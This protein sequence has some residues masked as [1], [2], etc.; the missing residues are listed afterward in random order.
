M[1]DDEPSEPESQLP[2]NS[3]NLIGITNKYENVETI[4]QMISFFVSVLVY[5][6]NNL[7]TLAQELA[8]IMRHKELF[9]A[10][11]KGLTKLDSDMSESTFAGKTLDTAVKHIRQLLEKYL[12]EIQLFMDIRELFDCVNTGRVFEFKKEV[13]GP[14]M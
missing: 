4:K 9:V 6:E 14:Q 8:T 3:I 5:N 13:R 10:E 12:K 7:G 2:I 1:L 11:V